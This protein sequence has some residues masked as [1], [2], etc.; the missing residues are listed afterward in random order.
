MKNPLLF[1]A[2]LFSFISMHSQ[3]IDDAFIIGKWKA[4]KA[5][6]IKNGD[7]PETKEYVD[8]FQKATFSFNADH[9]FSF[10]NKSDAKTMV[11]LAKMFND[12][13]KWIFD[14]KAM[15]I[16]IGKKGDGYSVASFS[17]T[18][19][20]DKIIFLVEETDIEL[21]MKKQ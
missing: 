7:K 15:K 2:F 11:M 4:K 5:T 16:K 9:T 21:V 8:G 1:L 3:T 12:K 19:K 14:Q 20:K 6:M 17:V 13:N 10:E 18:L